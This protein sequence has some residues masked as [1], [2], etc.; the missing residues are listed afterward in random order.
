VVRGAVAVAAQASTYGD[1]GLTARPVLVNGAV[2]AVSHKDGK[3]FSLGSLTV[4]GGRVVA[5]DILA[6]PARLA[7]LDPALFR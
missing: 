7:E 5:I 3:P 6:D 2:G 4:R 1:L